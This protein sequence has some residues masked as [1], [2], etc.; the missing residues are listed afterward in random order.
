MF[1]YIY[2]YVVCI[3]YTDI[4]LSIHGI[5]KQKCPRLTEGLGKEL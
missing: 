3:T 5:K 1:F 4:W 2:I